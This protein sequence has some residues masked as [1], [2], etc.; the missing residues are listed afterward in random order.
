MM[1]ALT[2]AASLFPFPEELF[3]AAP[4]RAAALMRMSFLS[5]ATGGK[6]SELALT[7]NP[8]EDHQVRVPIGDGHAAR[9]CGG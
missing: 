9:N 3:T 2:W 7:A 1:F 6:V 4:A 8:V 5:R